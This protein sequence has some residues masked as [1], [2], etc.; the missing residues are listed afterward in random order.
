MNFLLHVIGSLDVGIYTFLNGYAGNWFLDRI[1][2]FE[3][4]NDFFKGGIFLAA[5]A[6]LWF[7]VGADREKRRRAVI[8]IFAGTMLA[9]LVNRTIAGI[10][11]FRL[12]PMYAPGL[13]HHPYSF[14]IAYNLENWNSFPSDTATYFFGLAFG[15]GRLLPRCM[16]PLMLY[17]AVWICLPRVFLGEHYLSDLAVGGALGVT[18]VWAAFRSEWLRQGFATRVLGLMEVERGVFYAFAFLVCFEMGTV[19]GDI[20]SIGNQVIH[21]GR[22]AISL[23]APLALLVTAAFLALVA[24]A[25]FAVVRAFRGQPHHTALADRPIRPRTEGR[26]RTG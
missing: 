15:L 19:F 14:P 10:I 7:H 23:P 5:Y 26:R 3:E 8:A 11:P 21:L 22:M 16:A 18:T 20:R 1:A 17:T 12:R 9:L 6:Y 25:G 13:P 24:V 4:S 2:A